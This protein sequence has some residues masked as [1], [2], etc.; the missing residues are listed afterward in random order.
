MNQRF[1]S[2][3]DSEHESHAWMVGELHCISPFALFAL[4]QHRFEKLVGTLGTIQ[5]KG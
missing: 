5:I 3:R 4:S 2:G 1:A